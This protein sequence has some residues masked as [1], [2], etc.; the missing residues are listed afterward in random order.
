MACLSE[1][2]RIENETRPTYLFFP[3][4]EMSISEA[5]TTKER[6]LPKVCRM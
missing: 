6:S 3:E 1:K 4:R 5:I 2:K